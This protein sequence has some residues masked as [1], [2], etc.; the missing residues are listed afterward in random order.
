MNNPKIRFPAPPPQ[1]GGYSPGV[2]SDIPK[3]WR[4]GGRGRA[5]EAKP[6]GDGA[7]TKWG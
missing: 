7:D 5:W 2:A 4:R 6:M 1:R 3:G